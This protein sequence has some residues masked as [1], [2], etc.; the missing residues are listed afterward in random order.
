MNQLRIS[1][2]WVEQFRRYLSADEYAPTEAQ[3]DAT[4][5]GKFVPTRPVVLGGAFDRF[6]ERPALYYVPGSDVMVAGI[7]FPEA[8]VVEALAAVDLTGIP[9][10]KATREY[11]IGDDLVTVA[12]KADL[13]HGLRVRE[14]KTRWST[15]DMDTYRNGCQ[16]RFYLDV[17]GAGACDFAVFVM[18]EYESGDIVLRD[19]VQWSEYPYPGLHTDCEELLRGIVGYV[20]LRGL[21]RY[22]VARDATP[23]HAERVMAATETYMAGQA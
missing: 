6:L 11:V 23:T 3:L 13:L 14:F 10:V 8:L 21:E 16:W 18:S 17:F 2:T 15:F 7:T 5:M 22:C 1:V 20:H 19:I 12:A 9:Q 4:I